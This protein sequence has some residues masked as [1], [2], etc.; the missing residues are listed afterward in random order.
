MFPFVILN[1]DVNASMVHRGLIE[2]I[3]SCERYEPMYEDMVEGVK[4]LHRTAN[5]SSYEKEYLIEHYHPDAAL[6][7]YTKNNTLYR[8]MNRALVRLDLI[9]LTDYR[10]FIGDIAR[11]IRSLC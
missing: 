9:K 8:S 1:K 6:E 5:I 10:F 11:K 7:W 4:K 3:D 2:F